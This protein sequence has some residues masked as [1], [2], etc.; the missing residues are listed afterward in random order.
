MEDTLG[1]IEALLT[2]LRAKEKGQ[3]VRVTIYE[4]NASTSQTTAANIWNSHT[5]DEI[6]SVV[7]RGKE[8]E[9][10]L[11]IKFSD[12]GGIRVDDVAGVNDSECTKRFIEQVEIYGQNESGH[13]KRT[14]ALL[15]LGKAGMLLWKEMIGGHPGKPRRAGRTPRRTSAKSSC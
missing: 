6:V 7:P 11:K 13:K 2:H 3:T 10:K 8:V 12:P 14:D 1:L 4:K 15:A 5:P 9:E